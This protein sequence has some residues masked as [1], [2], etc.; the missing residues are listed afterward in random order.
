MADR[1]KR[2]PKVGRHVM[3]TPKCLPR[4]PRERGGKVRPKVIRPISEAF[5][6]DCRCDTMIGVITEQTSPS[7]HRDWN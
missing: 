4:L 5:A 7:C 1:G 6:I 2:Q 3:T